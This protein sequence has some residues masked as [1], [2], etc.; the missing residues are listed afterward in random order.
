VVPHDE[1]VDGTIFAELFVKSL[2]RIGRAELVASSRANEQ[3][4]HWFHRIERANDFVVYVTDPKPTNWTNL[5]LRQAQ[6]TIIV[7]GGET[8]FQPSTS[9]AMGQSEKNTARRA[10]LVLFRG[11]SSDTH[12]ARRWQ[13]IYPERRLHHVDSSEDAMR[14]A[15][16]VT[17]RGVGIVL[18]GGGARGFAHIGVMRALRD[19]KIAVDSIG[20]TSIGAIIAAGWAAGWDCQEMTQRMRAAFVATNPLNDYTWPLVS[21]VAG[22]KVG[23]LLRREFGDLDIEDLRLPYYCVSTNL[24][25]GQIAV[26]TRGKVWF[27]LR[28]SIAIPGVLPPVFTDHQVHV[29]G[30]TINNLPVDV[31]HEQKPGFVVAVDVGA[32]RSFETDLESTEVPSWWKLS[33]WLQGRRSRISIMQILWR[34][35]MINSTATTI[36]QRQLTDLL[37]RPALESIDLL[38]WQSFDRAIDLGYRCAAQALEKNRDRLA[39]IGS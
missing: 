33:H 18:S 3:T 27:W 13:R 17:G 6:A 19:A 15:R 38:D 11:N 12:N 5:C 7:V 39:S 36:G 9:L 23:Q 4:T 10:E 30:A 2:G 35:G 34:A 20:G 21:L 22:R 1:S 28:A 37:L 14:V 24:T 32:D 16:L 31:M 8:R 26:H 25:S 29:D